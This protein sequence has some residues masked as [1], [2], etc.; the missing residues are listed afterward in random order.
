[1][2]DDLHIAKSCC[3]AAGLLLLLVVPNLPDIHLASPASA[4]DSA[5]IRRQVHTAYLDWQYK[6]KTAAQRVMRGCWS[7]TAALVRVNKAAQPS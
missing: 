7:L 6:R 3:T 1:M 2:P 5:A 4:D